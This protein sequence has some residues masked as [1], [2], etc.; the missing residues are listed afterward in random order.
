M[1]RVKGIEPSLKAWE[2]SVLPLNYTRNILDALRH[3]RPCSWAQLGHPGPRV[4]LYKS[5]V[6]WLLF[7]DEDRDSPI[8]LHPLLIPLY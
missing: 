8:E 7:F 2:A 3:I 6:T 5:H 4:R 1:E